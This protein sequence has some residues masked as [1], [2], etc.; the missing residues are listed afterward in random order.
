V[1]LYVFTNSPLYVQFPAVCQDDLWLLESE[2]PTMAGQPANSRWE[3]AVPGARAS[4]SGEA[5]DM[6]RRLRQEAE[7]ERWRQHEEELQR[8]TSLEM[9]LWQTKKQSIA[10]AVVRDERAA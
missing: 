6:R 4:G 8:A 2:R 9:L 7:A 3:N 5:V 1:V 10:E